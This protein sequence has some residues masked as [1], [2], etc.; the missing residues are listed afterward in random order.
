MGKVAVCAFVLLLSLFMTK[1]IHAQTV[2]YPKFSPLET[3]ASPEFNV[4]KLRDFEFGQPMKIQD[5]TEDY[6][7]LLMEGKNVWVRRSDVLVPPNL[8]LLVPGAGFSVD[9]RPTLRFW[10]SLAQATEFLTATNVRKAAPDLEEVR[11][12]GNYEDL[13]MPILATDVV[14]VMGQSSIEMA[15]VM[16]P[17]SSARVGAFDTLR[18]AQTKEYDIV[19]VVDA[20]PDAVEFNRKIADSLYRNLRR[21]ITRAGDIANIRLGVYGANFFD[22]F[23]DL[24]AVDDARIQDLITGPTGVK[25]PLAEPLIEALHSVSPKLN[26]AVNKRLVIALSGS[27]IGNDVYV[28]ELRKRVTLTDPK[29][30]FPAETH[31]FLVQSTPEPG[32]R[33]VML[34]NATIEASKVTYI[35]F[36]TKL[37]EDVILLINRSLNLKLERELEYS[38]LVSACQVAKEFQH[39]PC[40][41]PFAATTDT[42]APKPTRRGKAS[43]WYSTITWVVV[44]GLILKKYSKE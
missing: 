31:L 43:S 23:N 42:S 19:L 3:A 39:F 24:G 12:E 41:F 16:L 44:D 35:P 27:E 17:I 30:T 11:V 2:A 25:L 8:G 5:K 4:L 32:D 6:I 10:N 29:L 40:I 34:A 7:H 18:G 26:S 15:A 14:D 36:S 20:S 13:R 28:S 38:E 9:K 21:S 1:S 22:N 33:L 37:Q